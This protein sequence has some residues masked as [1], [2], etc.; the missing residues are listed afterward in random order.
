MHT[1][2]KQGNE[3]GHVPKAAAV[4]PVRQPSADYAMPSGS[5]AMKRRAVDAS[6]LP[7][8][9][10]YGNP[11]ESS[12]GEVSVSAP[13]R[14]HNDL[15]FSFDIAAAKISAPTNNLLMHSLSENSNILADLPEKSAR[16][17]SGG[18]AFDMFRNYIA[19][20]DDAAVVSSATTPTESSREGNF[21]SNSS[22]KCSVL[23]TKRAFDEEERTSNY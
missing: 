21:S 17:L 7:S 18:E 3:G 4:A 9:H 6:T 13:E 8:R 1:A 5:V 11:L 16:P 20:N 23:G 22:P 14:L 19:Q 10:T 12:L 2:S 15:S